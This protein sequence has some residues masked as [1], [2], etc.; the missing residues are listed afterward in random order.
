M[1]FRRATKPVDSPGEAALTASLVGIG[2]NLAGPSRS[3][4]EPDIEDTLLFA[5]EEAMDR[6]DLRLLALLV[7]WFGTNARFVNAD[8]LTRLV[9]AHQSKRVRALWTALARSQR[10]DRR[11]LRLSKAYRG[12]RIDPGIKGSDFLIQRHGEDPRFQGGP[13]R[14]AANLLRDRRA[15][16]LTPSELAAR[17]LAYRYR[18]LI[19]PTYRADMWAALE[20]EPSLTATMLAKRTYG[21]YATAWNVKKDFALLHG[22]SQTKRGTTRLFV[23]A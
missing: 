1:A 18:V 12:R 9:E 11:F 14:V 2:M 10:S 19:G 3:V 5:S 23:G 20:R 8:R 4:T 13:L 22:R 6:F 21:S 17:H 7:T 16:I 15:D